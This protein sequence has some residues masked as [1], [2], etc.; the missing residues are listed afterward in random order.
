MKRETY[1]E[2]EENDEISRR[3]PLYIPFLDDLIIKN[4]LPPL[5][6]QIE[7]EFLNV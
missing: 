7:P 3:I 2:N 4:S 5:P 6:P 1:E